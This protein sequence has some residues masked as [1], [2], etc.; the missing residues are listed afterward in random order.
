[1]ACAYAQEGVH[2]HLHGR[3]LD[4]NRGPRTHSVG[5]HVP[6][7]SVELARLLSRRS[8]VRIVTDR[9]IASPNLR[10]T[11]WCDLMTPALKYRVIIV[12][13]CGVAVQ[14]IVR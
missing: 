9:S 4:S 14:R 5:I 12:Y 2:G 13:G 3:E 6:T 8:C 1:M 7:R 11:R 10:D